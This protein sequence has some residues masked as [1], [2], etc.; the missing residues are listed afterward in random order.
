MGPSTPRPDR[1]RRGGKGTHLQSEEE[2]LAKSE[3]GQPP[4]SVW[5]SRTNSPL[6][7]TIQD[8]QGIDS[9]HNVEPFQENQAERPE[10]ET[11]QGLPMQCWI[12]KT[13]PNCRSPSPIIGATFLNYGYI[14]LQ[15]NVTLQFASS[16][17]SLPNGW[18]LTLSQGSYIPQAS[19]YP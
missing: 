6:A 10:P 17:S 11:S 4:S 14:S 8:R 16:V 9:S 18:W 7:R 3:Y 1:C 2:C 13:N 12:A 15:S 19:A 5:R